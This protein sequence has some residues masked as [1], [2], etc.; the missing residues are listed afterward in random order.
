MKL[1]RI[2]FIVLT[3]IYIVASLITYKQST[4]ED[5]VL[6]F[7]AMSATVYGAVLA[8]VFYIRPKLFGRGKVDIGIVA[9]L[10]LFIISW[11][12]LSFC[13]YQVQTYEKTLSD[14]FFES[15]SLLISLAAFLLLFAYEG[16][17]AWFTFFWK[18]GETLGTRIA[19]EAFFA[20]C[21]GILL[22]FV[23]IGANGKIANVCLV[24]IP[25]GYCL[26]ALHNYF[27]LNYLDSN[28]INK[29]SYGII[30]IITTFICYIPFASF[31]MNLTDGKG[32]GVII[33]GIGVGILV[34]SLTYIMY[35]NQ[36]NQFRQVVSL[37]KE[38]GQTSADL[39]F[40]Q[41]QI[42]PH[43]LFNVMNTI[44]GIALQ[45]NAERTAEGVQKLS[46]MMRFMLHENQQDSVLLSREL[47][48]LKEYIDLQKLRTVSSPTIQI[49]YDIPEIFEQYYITPMLLIPFVE[50]AF[51][52]GI[53]LN[54][55]SWVRI[56]LNVENNHIKFSV[57]NSIHKVQDHD[58]ES[59]KSGI[60]LDNVKKRLNLVYKGKHQLT[61]EE[62][63]KEYF[64]FLTLDLHS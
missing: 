54:K 64:V 58:P 28:K 40:L 1:R 5:K 3:I 52:H 42:N 6:P 22:F 36:R 18:R 62:T 63:Q 32:D 10:F 38:L 50:N 16:I 47:E 37:Q 51:K 45:E 57:Y 25:Y 41:S 44:Y 24:S 21:A 46:D 39:K 23:S 34:I 26:Y 56:H 59:S 14:N 20:M 9:T 43:F 49:S 35:F 8:F 15:P 29:L 53:S 13:F 4:Y 12:L 30:T 17:K 31:F 19:K 27:L 7:Q 2:E 61:I 55:P 48:Y 33:L 11:T 60:G